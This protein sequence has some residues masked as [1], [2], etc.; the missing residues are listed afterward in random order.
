[1]KVFHSI[2]L[3]SL[4]LFI[5]AL[6]IAD[7]LPSSPDAAIYF[8]MP[9]PDNLSTVDAWGG[10][11]SPPDK[12]TDNISKNID[13]KK[14]VILFDKPIDVGSGFRDALV[15]VS[16]DLGLYGSLGLTE[17]IR[18]TPGWSSVPISSV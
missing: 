7:I 4:A 10:F 8:N 11:D 3:F 16:F 5:P 15:S 17:N 12:T 13:E 6:V 18:R 2:L 1:M 14:P 9:A